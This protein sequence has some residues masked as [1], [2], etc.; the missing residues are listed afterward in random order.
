MSS[1]KIIINVKLYATLIF[2]ENMSLKK[3]A[4]D[5][6]THSKGTLPSVHNQTL[7]QD[8]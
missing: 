5:Q 3:F 1:I 2:H 6:I 7:F 4:V 8:D